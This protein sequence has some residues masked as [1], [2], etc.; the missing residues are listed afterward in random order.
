MALCSFTIASLPGYEHLGITSSIILIVCRMVQGFSS[1]GEV[2]GAQ[3]YS[4][5]ASLLCFFTVLYLVAVHTFK[6]SPEHISCR[7]AGNSSRESSQE[8]GPRQGKI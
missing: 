2:I 8:V 7:H 1:L 5:I 6:P 4:G 3:V